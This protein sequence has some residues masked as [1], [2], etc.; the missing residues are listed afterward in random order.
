[1]EKTRQDLWEA[2]GELPPAA[3]EVR[4]KR[5][6]VEENE[7]FFLERLVLDLNGYEQVPAI[8]VRPQNASVP[9]PAVL[10]NH[11]HGNLF[12][13]GKQELL[14]G[15][16]YMLRRGYAY[17]LAEAGIASL[18]IDHMC[19]EERRGM[20]ESA[21]YKRLIWDGYYMWAWMVFDSIRAL[22]YLCSRAEVDARRI[23]TI[24]MSMG[25]CMAQWVA[26]LDE[27]VKVCV[28]ICCL[29]NFDELAA[30][31]RFDQHGIYY[32]IPGLRKK[33]TTAQLNGLIAP[34]A[35]L[36]LIGQFDPHTPERG[37]QKDEQEIRKIYASLNAEPNWKLL[38]Y[39]VG[40]VETLEMRS[41]AMR[42][43]REHL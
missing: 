20:T 12:E 21:A 5:L 27:R 38:R 36:A 9:V 33:F 41:D 28:D 2:M 19:F 23:A 34:R 1:M 10:F 29:T 24:G 40:H 18:C 42:F 8:F 39:P 26:A 17:D 32:Y 14:D 16:D 43:L 37:V 31:K 13:I 6:C 11:S 3:G 30:E 4:A 25:S 15:C 7:T 22:D 35:H